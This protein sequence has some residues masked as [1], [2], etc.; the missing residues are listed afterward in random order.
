VCAKLDHWGEVIGVPDSRWPGQY[1][2]P[3]HCRLRKEDVSGL[4]LDLCVDRR[5]TDRPVRCCRL[6]RAVV[7]AVML[8]PASSSYRHRMTVVCV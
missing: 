4:L 3:V 2:L 6:L 7:S 5:S 8:S 1:G